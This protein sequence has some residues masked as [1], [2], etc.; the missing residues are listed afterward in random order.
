MSVTSKGRRILAGAATS[1]VLVATIATA[2]APAA[3]AA[4]KSG[5]T[6]IFVTQQQQL[7]HL[8]PTRVYTGRDLAFLNT[9]LFR[10][11]VAYKY[12]AGNAGYQL[13]PDLA[14]NNGVPSNKAKTWT[15]TL[16]PGITWEDGS[17]IT[18]GDVKYGISRAFAQDVLSDG[19][20]YAIQ[21]FAIP[22]NADGSSK[23]PGP[24]K[25][26]KAQTALYDKA[27]QCKG[28]TITIHLNKS[29][30]DFNYF[31]TYPA[32]SPVKKSKDTG[33]KYDLRP[34][35]SGPYKISAYKIG[36]SLTLVRNTK[37]N[38]KSDPIRTPYPDSIEVRFGIQPDVIDQIMKTD[39][40]PNAVSFDGLLPQDV[41][42]YFSNPSTAKRGML[43]MDP[44]T[45][46]M[47]V[48]SA[49]MNCLAAR[50]ALFF[51]WNTQAII[52]ANGG[53][54][55]YGTPGDNAIKPNLGPDYA[56]TTGNIH[57]P[58]W[59]ATG[60]AAY[61]KTFLDQAKTQCPSAYTKLTST[62]ISIDL[63]NTPTYKSW[64]PSVSAAMKA[65]GIV[66]NFNFIPSGQYYSTIMNTAKQGDM[67]RSGWG[68]DWANASTVLPPLFL[69]NGGFDLSQ[70]WNDPAYA[71]FSK[72]VD[73]AMGETNRAKQSVLWHKAAQYAMD[74]YWIL[75]VMFPKTA[76]AFGSGV[77]GVQWWGPQG[78]FLYPTMY[79]K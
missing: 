40:I 14:T 51:A 41:P 43:V 62:G 1:A 63:P 58:N 52:D 59:K 10:T 12:K 67:S 76:D 39:S 47:A 26:T 21:Y 46:Y 3:S 74:Q 19:P 24:Y 49:S 55:Y 5:G 50:K 79:L 11:L 38:Q 61:A 27:V 56:P 25:A 73:Q 70:N 64:T 7:D 72:L 54:Q 13:T 17:P 16:R 65:A 9:Y 2:A 78:T 4:G 53:T 37:W 44:Y 68:A 35:S 28:N 36:D 29:V 32:M 20:T 15:W 77:G 66:V 31:G 34:F 33:E 48:N 75:G 23:Y 22:Q 8:D 18:C 6:L 69:K 71:G 45:R 60:N 30:A 42:A 57:D